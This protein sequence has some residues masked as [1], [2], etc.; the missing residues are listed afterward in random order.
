MTGRLE[1]LVKVG[2]DIG[3]FSSEEEVEATAVAL[4]VSVA[5]PMVLSRESLEG[6]GGPSEDSLLES[7]ISLQSGETAYS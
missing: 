7:D 3:T 1:S 5:N 6:I 2:S 4:P